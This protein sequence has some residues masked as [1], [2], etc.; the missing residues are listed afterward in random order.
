MSALLFSLKGKTALITGATG[1]IGEGMA[2]GLAEAGANIIFTYRSNPEKT[3][4]LLQKV[5]ADIGVVPVHADFGTPDELLVEKVVAEAI[6]KSPT[7]QVDILI[8]NAG[9]QYRSPF[10]DFPQ[11]EWD[12]V[13]QVNLNA[14]VQLTRHIGRH[15]LERGIKGRVIFT[16]LLLLFSGGLN[17]AAYA[18]SKGAIKQITMSLSNEWSKHGITVNS[19]APGY[20]DTA[21]NTNLKKDEA[22]F[23]QLLARIPAGRWGT[24]EDFKGPVVFLASDA[25]AYVTGTTMLVD[26]GWTGW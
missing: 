6:A 25:S 15:F 1:G 5:N 13:L 23:T 3:V 24:P 20:I 7:G 22:R 2:T 10:Q 18:A 26:G 8:N 12:N 11:N 14:P 17:V 21:M 19:I 16:A 4:A 9:V